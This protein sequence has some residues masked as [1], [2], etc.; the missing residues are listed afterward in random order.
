MSILRQ[1]LVLAIVHRRVAC[2]SLA[3]DPAAGKL[4]TETVALRVSVD[5]PG[6][7]AG[8]AKPS[9]PTVA[10]GLVSGGGRFARKLTFTP[11]RKNGAPVS[12]E[13]TLTRCSQLEPRPDGQ[14][15]LHLK[16]ASNGPGVLEVGKTVAPKYQQGKENGA[17]VVVGVSC[18]RMALP[19]WYPG[20][21]A[22]GIARAL[23]IC[24]GA[25]LDA[26]NVAARQQV[27]PG[28]GRWRR[29]S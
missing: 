16:R 9:D 11:A 26:I 10:P 4:R 25:L 5:A 21:R 2:Q 23:G 7:S 18:L 15:G 29:H 24:R 1:C 20:H 28:Q 17:L 22:D 12:S 13:T 14:Y 27:R 3:A 19:T 6:Q 8:H